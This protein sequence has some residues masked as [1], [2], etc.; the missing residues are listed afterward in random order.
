MNILE[1]YLQKYNQL[2]ILILGLP[3]TN[4]SAIAKEFSL[5][6]NLPSININHYLI[7]DKFIEKN[8]ENIN[9]RIYED[10]KII[11]WQEL[12]IKINSLKSKGL[13]VY[14]NFIDNSK[15]DWTFDF[16]FFYSMNN[17][18]CKQILFEKKLLDW[19]E[20]EP[21]TEIYFKNIFEPFYDEQKKKI[22]INKFFN[23]KIKK[24]FN[25]I[26]HTIF[27]LLMSLILK[28]L[29]SKSKIKKNNLHINYSEK[30]VKF[31]QQLQP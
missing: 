24:T 25:S 16:S 28:K 3:C 9:F 27:D 5:D 18:L 23:L 14:G 19:E 7:K 17:K 6:L 2:I 15:I 20:S 1:A 21:K 31:N 11:N 12:N 29:K 13:I 4:K 10:T 30:K 26:Y 22:K 8:I